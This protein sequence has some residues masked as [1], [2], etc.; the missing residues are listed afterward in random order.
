MAG[1][2]HLRE[3]A[4]PSASVGINQKPSH[5]SET[6]SPRVTSGA[7]ARHSNDSYGTAEAVPFQTRCMR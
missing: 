6:L 3:T 1:S 4:D 2:E 5:K 7:E